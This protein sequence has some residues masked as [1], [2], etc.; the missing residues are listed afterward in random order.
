MYEASFDLT[1]KVALV[2]GGGRGIGRA[3]AEGLSHAGAEVALTARTGEQ[4][5]QAA[6]EIASETG[7][8]T[9]GLSCDV[10]DKASIES[11]V[12]M[13]LE[14]FGHIDILVNNAERRSGGRRW[15]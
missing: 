14:E 12:A 1:G 2:T 11:A 5:T 7:R 4:V 8:R 3:L 13:V 10:T 15:T 9:R 6:E